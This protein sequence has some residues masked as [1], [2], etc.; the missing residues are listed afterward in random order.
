MVLRLRTFRFILRLAMYL[1]PLVSFASAGYIRF[2]LFGP[3]E[4]PRAEY[5]Y[6]LLFTIVVWSIAAERYKVTSIDKLI[7]E[8][9]GIRAVIGAFSVT[10][11]INLI[12]LFFVRSFSYSRL[13]L[14]V[15]VIVFLSLVIMVRFLF[16]VILRR[17]ASQGPGDKVLI[18]G[19]SRFARR[20]ARRLGSNSFANCAVAGFVSLPG[21]V[22]CSENAPVYTLCEIAQLEAL[23]VNS[24]VIAVTPERYGR[25]RSYVAALEPLCKPIQ[26]VVDIGG[27]LVLRERLFHF[28]GLQLLDLDPSPTTSLQYSIAKRVFDIVLSLATLILLAPVFVVIA[29]AIKL[30]SPGPVL[31][32]QER[33]GLNGSQFCMY[34]FRSMRVSETAESDTRWTTSEDPRRTPIGSFLRK[35]SAD[36]LPQL[37]NVL[38]GDMSIVGPRPERPHFV[39]RFRQN[40]RYYHSRHRLKVGIT[41]WAQVN[42]WRGDTSIKKRLECDL[43]YLEN[44]SLLLD[45]R[46]V[47]MTLWSVVRGKN[48]Q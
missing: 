21:E 28:G 3:I 8:K 14:V 39:K 30:T 35:T 40:F 46:I 27:G 38:K 13:F 9:T 6:L 45:F 33:I 37:F 43:Y 24:V 1:L 20:V 16:R 42:G 2:I 23:D 17:I 47:V 4:I 7:S 18:V 36:E 19:A 15:N 41:G 32:R 11:I 31:F 5:L 12:V 26:V 22:A 25:I 10:Y 29:I 44:W 48:A 34:K